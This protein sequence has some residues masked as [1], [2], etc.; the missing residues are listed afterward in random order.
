[1]SRRISTAVVM[2]ALAAAQLVGSPG[3][4]AAGGPAH[5]T[6]PD[7]GL[8][9]GTTLQ[10]CVD[11]ASPGDYIEIH[12]DTPTGGATINKSLTIWPDTGFRPTVGPLTVNITS[13]TAELLFQDLT[14][15]GAVTV[16]LTGGTNHHVVI[17]R[18]DVTETT[19]DAIHLGTFVPATFEVTDTSATNTGSEADV[20]EVEALQPAPGLVTARLIGNRFSGAGN[21]MAGVGIVVGVNN[22]GTIHADIYNNVVHDVARGGGNFGSSLWINAENSTTTVAN[23]V[24][25]T[26]E[27]S[28][29][30]GMIVRTLLNGVGSLSVD[31]FDNIF[32]NAAQAA[33]RMQDT[34]PARVTMRA[35][36]NDFNANGRPNRLEGQSL[37][38]NNKAV[39]PD[40]V[41][42][43]AGDLRL[44]STSPLID[45][46]RVCTAGGLANLDAAAHGRLAGVSTDMGAYER[47]AGVP[48]GIAVVGTDD[49]DTMS[50]T[51]GADIICGL[52]G[53]DVLHGNRGGDYIDGGPGPDVLIGGH[54]Q[55]RLFGGSGDDLLC[56]HDGVS[57]NDELAGGSGDDS[58]SA[59][60]GDSK[61]QL[62]HATT[63]AA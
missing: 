34:T 19:L 52:G 5:W 42:E 4:V 27:R 24:G 38:T 43:P 22:S 9:S 3:P 12:T 50:G 57:G 51:D 13:G 11:N 37:G 6:F 35:G 28:G 18:L 54:G 59:D 33:V 15:N 62:E 63:C 46:G 49:A 29:G 60:S 47:G 32:S 44:T 39:A 58:Y 25:N 7:C 8:G 21:A 36:Y 10:Q 17:N 31:A 26:F 23:V 45:Q 41:D 2:V 53:A 55:D 40:Y 61:S 30:E 14:V 48:T 16:S 20:I 1:M 56:A